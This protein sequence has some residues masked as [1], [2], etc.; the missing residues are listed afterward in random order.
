MQY[1][2]ADEFDLPMQREI[3]LEIARNEKD[4]SKIQSAYERAAAVGS[5]EALMFLGDFHR[6]LNEYSQAREYYYRA[7]LQP[8]GLQKALSSLRELLKLSVETEYVTRTRISELRFHYN[9]IC[10]AQIPVDFDLAA[11]SPILINVIK[12][13]CL[14][15]GIRVAN[16]PNQD[17][18]PHDR[19]EQVY[20]HFVAASFGLS[21]SVIVKLFG[22][23][24]D[25]KISTLLHIAAAKLISAK[26]VSDYEN[27]VLP[28]INRRL[29]WML[30]AL[31]NHSTVEVRECAEYLHNHVLNNEPALVT[32]PERIAKLLASNIFPECLHEKFK[33]ARLQAAMHKANLRDTLAYVRQ[34]GAEDD[35]VKNRRFSF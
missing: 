26:I 4:P 12:T 14:S 28:D 6:K 9:I 18:K 21:D 35:S 2:E 20:W 19:T 29:T 7:G 31:R 33:E 23:D 5:V 16:S 24:I 32:L 8:N 27:V 17:Y 30:E 13:C 22:P 10:K 15:D 34:C 3:F 1:S 25:L 11:E